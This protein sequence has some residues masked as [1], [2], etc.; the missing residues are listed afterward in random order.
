MPAFASC[1]VCRE[2]L[3]VVRQ[4]IETLYGGVVCTGCKRVFCLNCLKKTLNT[5]LGKPCPKCGGQV[6][7]AT[8]DVIPRSPSRLPDVTY[9]P[10]N[11][12]IAVTPFY[13]SDNRSAR[14]TYLYLLQKTKTPSQGLM[15]TILDWWRGQHPNQTFEMLRSTL[16]WP[17]RALMRENVMQCR[18]RSLSCLR[19][20]RFS[21]R[22][23][24]VQH[25]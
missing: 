10:P 24:S 25:Q 21:I 22:S 17:A 14:V 7:P 11:G 20:I 8:P 1:S 3:S 16:N 23:T 2:P 6:L 18:R 12:R 5:P 4:Q 19:A 9:L 13:L 15:W